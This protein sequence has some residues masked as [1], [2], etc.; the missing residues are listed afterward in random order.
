MM[1]IQLGSHLEKQSLLVI[2]MSTRRHHGISEKQYQSGENLSKYVTKPKPRNHEIQGEYINFVNRKEWQ[3]ERHICNL[4][5]ID[6]I[7][8]IY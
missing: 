3:A 8:L 5:H 2:Y 4:S 1:L 6:L 7:F